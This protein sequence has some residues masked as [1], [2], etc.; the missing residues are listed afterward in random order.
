M[1]V[2]LPRCWKMDLSERR[3]D[4]V[5]MPLRK[6]ITIVQTEMLQGSNIVTRGQG[7]VPRGLRLS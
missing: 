7:I 1:Q 3:L 2:R 6:S 4:A 5:L